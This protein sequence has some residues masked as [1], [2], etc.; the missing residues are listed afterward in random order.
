VGTF[1]TAIRPR[2]PAPTT[3]N[4]SLNRLV[5]RIAIRAEMLSEDMA[6]TAFVDLH[7]VTDSLRRIDHQIIYGRR[8]AGKTHAFRNLAKTV[9]RE[10]DLPVY[11]DLRTIG[12]SGGLYGDTTQSLA[13]R[14]SQ[15]LIDVLEA[16]HT[17]LVDK[18]IDDEHF[19]ALLDRL[20]DIAEAVTEVRVEGPVTVTSE[21][22]RESEYQH[23]SSLGGKAQ[24]G[25][26]GI[27]ASL[28]KARS[29]KSASR[30]GTK[31]AIQRS[32]NEVPRILFGRLSKTI[33]AA[34]A[35][36]APRRIW[37]LLDEWSS[38]P[39]DLQPLLADMLRRALFACH[40]ITVKIGAIERRSAFATRGVDSANY[41]GIEL[42]ADTAA[43]LNL[44][45]HLVHGDEDRSA[46]F[47]E[48]LYRHLMAFM[49][50]LNRAF[51]IS[52]ANELGQIMF[53]PGALA[54]YVRAAEGVPRD[55]L[56]IAY[57]AAQHAG[58]HPI[59]VENIQTAA[60]K[61]YLQDKEPGI[62]GNTQAN[63]VWAKLQKDVVSRRRSRTFLIRRDRER[64]HSGILDLYD[65]RLIHLLEPGLMNGADPGVL[66][67]GYCLDYGSYVSILQKAELS[68]AWDSSR[69]PWQYR[70]GE[71]FL[72][73]VF[74]E[75]AIFSPIDQTGIGSPRRRG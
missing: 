49:K 19:A 48:L 13:T 1:Q 6:D 55:A 20:D 30:N 50:S 8:G 35:A 34:T 67:D 12:S 45:E 61:H 42:G 58:R 3:R 4:E 41:V 10:G 23:E 5:M 16:F 14:G 64:T 37:L 43:A 32:G 40:G 21:F 46:F 53:G 39:L 69:R 65:A 73:D 51:V 60:R 17:K 18:A 36:I 47:T 75:S 7:Q 11:L 9:E 72:P 70:R 52:N 28:G 63:K 44:D 24:I 26:S 62:I 2:D 33:S 74:D 38:L 31:R 29:R 22:S 56:Q 25:S 54:E 27:A 66:Y 15:L 59:T 71:A 57:H 68:A